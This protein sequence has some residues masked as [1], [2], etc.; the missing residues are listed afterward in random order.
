MIVSYLVRHWRG[1]LS[2]VQGYWINFVLIC[3]LGQYGSNF[4][5]D[6]L[7]DSVTGTNGENVYRLMSLV[8]SVVIG[9]FIWACVGAWRSASREKRQ[10]EKNR[11]WAAWVR[12]SMVLTVTGFIW[13]LTEWYDDAEELWPLAFPVGG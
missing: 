3:V 1:E 6:S 12:F 2:R 11:A 13:Q 5:L 4:F 9:I 8:W 7:A 10:D